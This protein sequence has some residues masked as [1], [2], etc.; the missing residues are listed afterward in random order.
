MIEKSI[1][2]KYSLKRKMFLCKEMDLDIADVF[3]FLPAIFTID[4]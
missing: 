4:N 1:T 2:N 3:P